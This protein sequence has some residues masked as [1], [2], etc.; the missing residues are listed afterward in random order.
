MMLI[1]AFILA[2]SV[3]ASCCA[4][5]GL[6]QYLHLLKEMFQRESSERDLW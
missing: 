2:G 1:L 5:L 3:L 6:Y 4:M